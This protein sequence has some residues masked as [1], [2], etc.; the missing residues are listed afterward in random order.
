M[1][2]VACGFQV[3]N[4]MAMMA[5]ATFHIAADYL[6]NVSSILESMVLRS[7]GLTI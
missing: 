6:F 5:A 1:D 2:L 3:C 7:L 4:S